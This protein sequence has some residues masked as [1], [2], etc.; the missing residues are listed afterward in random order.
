[1]VGET[2]GGLQ[3]VGVEA[4]RGVEWERPG[5]VLVGAVGFVDEGL[6]GFDGDARRHLARD[7]AAHSVG[8]D[9]EAEI[10]ACAVAVFVAAAPK[11]G[12]GANGPGQSHERE[13][14]QAWGG[15]IR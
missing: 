3:A 8:D 6:D 1:M 2:K 9:E 5:P 13:R 7:V 10:G 4:D 15:G 14:F 12:V 11:A